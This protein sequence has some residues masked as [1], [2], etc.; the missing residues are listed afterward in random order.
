MKTFKVGRRFLRY[1]KES[2][3]QQGQATRTMITYLCGVGQVSLDP[4]VT[5]R[6][7]PDNVLLDLFDFYRA[8]DNKPQQMW[9]RLVHVCQRWRYVVFASPL[10]LRLSLLCSARTPAR[11]TL[12]VWPPLPIRIFAGLIDGGDDNIIAALERHDRICEIML[13]LTSSLQ[14]RFETVTQEPFPILWGLFLNSAQAMPAL[15]DAFLGGSAPR[16][17]SLVL[18]GI[19]FPA[20][21]KLLLSCNDLVTLQLIRI[22]NIGYISPEAIVTGVSTLTRLETLNIRFESPAS[23]PDRRGRRAPPL[24]RALLPALTVFQF[25]GVSEYLEDL[26]ARINAPL[27]QRVEIMFFNQL[28]FDIRQLPQFIGHVGM[29]TSYNRAEV[30][31]SGTLVRINLYSPEGTS[32]PKRLMLGILC[33][34]ADWQVSSMTQICGQNSFL[35]SSVEQLDMTSWDLDRLESTG[36]VDQDDTQWLELFPPFTAVRTLRI[37]RGLRSLMAPA[38]QQLAEEMATD[39]LPAL[40]SLYLEEYRSSESEQQAIEPIPIFTARQS[41]DHPVVVH[42]WERS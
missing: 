33:K 41:S 25:H 35:L 29:L 6:M 31:L 4:R 36:Q 18:D 16:L 15:P 2:G 37:S 39:L 38:L 26:V 12:D 19:P 1:R 21:P 3:M 5:I 27:L 34:G 30:A 7:L 11:K 14:P 9:H 40:D 8:Q 17:Q 22:P 32:P 13:T 28:I 20:L 42:S 23:R 10:R 24:T